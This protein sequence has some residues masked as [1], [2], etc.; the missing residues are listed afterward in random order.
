M[1]VKGNAVNLTNV[2]HG[3]P[4]HNVDPADIMQTMQTI[5]Q[6]FLNQTTEIEH[7]KQE[8]E[9]ETSTIQMLQNRVFFLEAEQN[10]LSKLPSSQEFSTYLSGMNN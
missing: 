6:M 10:E 8:S 4:G 5:M 9:K 3:F 7:F 1:L 2:I